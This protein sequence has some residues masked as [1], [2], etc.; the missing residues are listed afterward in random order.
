[1]VAGLEWAVLYG[2]GRAGT[3]S[4]GRGKVLSPSRSGAPGFRQV[5]HD[6]PAPRAREREIGERA[7]DTL[8]AALAEHPPGVASAPGTTDL[9]APAFLEGAVPGRRRAALRE[10]RRRVMAD[11]PPARARDAVAPAALRAFDRLCLG[12]HADVDE[13]GPAVLTGCL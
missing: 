12:P 8:A 6:G 7:E 9:T 2:L 13:R 5:V 3:A 1:M 11:E 10:L 4:R